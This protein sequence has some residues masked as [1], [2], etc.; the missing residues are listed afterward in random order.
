[1]LIIITTN[2]FKKDLKRASKRGKRID[3][4]ETV[5][6]LLQAQETLEIRYRNHQLVGNWFPCWECHIEPDWLLIYQLTSTELILIRTGS[7]SHL[8]D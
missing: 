5:I 8:F 2:Q 3:K 6:N 7:H 4:L 1:L